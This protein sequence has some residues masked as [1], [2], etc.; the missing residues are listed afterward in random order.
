M[1]TQITD[2]E[3]QEVKEV[4]A[5]SDIVNNIDVAYINAATDEMYKHQPFVLSLLLGYR[6][7]LQPD[8]FEEIGKVIFLIWEYFKKRSKVKARQISEVQFNAK[9]DQLISMLK[10][11]EGAKNSTKGKRIVID[12]FKNLTSTALFAGVLVRFDTREP[13][14]SMNKEKRAILLAG[15]KSLIE[16]FESL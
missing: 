15:M 14:H 5:L 8:E 1:K 7:D 12:D 11:I 9:Q 16:C 4:S 13:L 10:Y 3:A 2:K 6:V